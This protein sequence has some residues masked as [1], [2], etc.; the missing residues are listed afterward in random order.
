MVSNLASCQEKLTLHS[1]SP[2]TS[3]FL[4]FPTL[5]PFTLIIPNDRQAL[6]DISLTKILLRCLD[7]VS[8][9]L[10]HA[11]HSSPASLLNDKRFDS[12][13]LPGIISCTITPSSGSLLAIPMSFFFFCFDYM[14]RIFISPHVCF[15]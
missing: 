5:L 11:V 10:P 3:P 14:S 15:L 13:N 4:S 7:S 2:L 6:Y 9:A 12:V 1:L 8:L